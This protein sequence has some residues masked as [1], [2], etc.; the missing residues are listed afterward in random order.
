MKSSYEFQLDFLT[1]KIKIMSNNSNQSGTLLLLAVVLGGAVYALMFFGS[2]LEQKNMSASFGQMSTTS[3]TGLFS[4]SKK[5]MAS[6]LSSNEKRSDLS[7]VVLPNFKMKSTSGADYSQISNPDFPSTEVSQ[8]DIQDLNTP[9]ASNKTSN[10]T[11]YANNLAQSYAF[12]NAAVEYISNPQN[13]TKSDINGLLLL[14][15]RAA[16]SAMSAQQGSK[17][18]TPALAAK[19]AS[20]ST[21]L[22]TKSGVKKIGGDPGD[23]G[24]S[25]PVGDGM[26]ILLMFAVV[27]AVFP[28]SKYLVAQK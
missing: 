15:T 6:D 17:R 28:E 8:M 18:T 1:Q 7:G 24:A 21:S 25:L 20:V 4:G 11:N 26:W 5:T 13:P 10:N 22:A 23:P 9:S 27:Y 16:A 19:T 2:S 14:D 3:S 12:G